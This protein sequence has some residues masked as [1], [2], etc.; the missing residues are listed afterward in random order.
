M[1]NQN[2]NQNKKPLLSLTCQSTGLVLAWTLYMYVPSAL[3]RALLVRVPA[4][5]TWAAA[6]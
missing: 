4:G 6:L 2:Q 1:P 5:H 3:A